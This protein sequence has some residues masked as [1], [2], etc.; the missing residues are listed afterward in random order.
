VYREFPLRLLE[1]CEDTITDLYMTTGNIYLLTCHIENIGFT[2][3]G[4]LAFGQMSADQRWNSGEPS[5]SE[6]TLCAHNL[7][8]IVAKPANQ[9]QPSFGPKVEIERL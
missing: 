2:H 6:T 8:A 3:D 9:S 4:S 1:N 5:V 7:A